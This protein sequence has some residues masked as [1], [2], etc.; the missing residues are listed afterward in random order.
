MAYGDHTFK[1]DFILGA[2]QESIEFLRQYYFFFYFSLVL[3]CRELN[4]IYHQ[5]DRD[6]FFRR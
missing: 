6:F 4:R 3:F 1:I 5:L 2:E